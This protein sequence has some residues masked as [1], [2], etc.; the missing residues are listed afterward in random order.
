MHRCFHCP[1]CRVALRSNAD[2]A[3][4]AGWGAGIAIAVVVVLI[5]RHLTG[6]WGVTLAFSEIAVVLAYLGGLAVYGR[7]MNIV[8]APEMAPCAQR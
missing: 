6:N 8:P 7:V 2:T 1:R 5:T 3:T 4:W